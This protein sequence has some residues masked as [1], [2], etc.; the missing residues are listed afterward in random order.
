MNE[1]GDRNEEMTHG[2]LNAVVG[3]DERGVGRG[4]FCVGLRKRKRPLSML[5]LRM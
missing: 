3:K 4:E 5:F 2:D 1:L